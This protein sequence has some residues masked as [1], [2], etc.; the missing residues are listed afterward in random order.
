MIVTKDKHTIEYSFKEIENAK[1]NIILC[2][3]ITSDKNEYN[4]FFLKFEAEILGQGLNSMR[5][6]FRGHGD[7]NFREED[8]TIAGELTDLETVSDFL[9]QENK[10][11]Q[12]I[13][14]SSFGSVSSILHAKAKPSY[15]EGLILLNPVLDIKKTFISPGTAWS[16]K[17]INEKSISHLDEVG[18]IKLDDY[19]M[20]PD[21][22]SEFSQLSLLPSF[23]DLD[24]PIFILHGDDDNMVPLEY[25]IIFSKLNDDATLSVVEG[26]GHGFDDQ[27]DFVVKESIDWIK[28]QL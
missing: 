15:L 26:V 20:G 5:F 8:M 16:Q 13:I 18:F 9:H 21:L 14:A 22:V 27:Q 10:L 11:P 2:H 24:I 6:D 19:K 25:S 7:S 3:G 1:A 28:R 12:Y 17:S 4:N 23:I